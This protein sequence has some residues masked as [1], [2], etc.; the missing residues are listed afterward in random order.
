MRRRVLGLLAVAIAVAASG[1]PAV[2]VADSGSKTRAAAASSRL[3]V[4]EV[5]YRLTLS[6][7]AVRAGPVSLEAIDRGM[8]PH[9]LRLRRT[10]TR[11]E[12]AVGQ[13]TPRERWDGV[14]HLAPGVYSLWCSLPEHAKLGMHATLRVLR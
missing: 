4:I 2:G 3:Q 9:D 7:G 1:L 10:G 12:I 6:R 13:L 14:V 11:R 5:E 8:D